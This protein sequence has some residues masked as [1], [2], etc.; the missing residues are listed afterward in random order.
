MAKNE[1][2]QASGP[3]N[4][5]GGA[6]CLLWTKLKRGRQS[7]L[8]TPKEAQAAA[9]PHLSCAQQASQCR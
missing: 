8:P 4:S 7:I 1:F 5:S 6:K 9:T 3:F 2:K